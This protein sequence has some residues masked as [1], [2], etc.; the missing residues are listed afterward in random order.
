MKYDLRK[1]MLNAWKIY[2]K[3]GCSFSEALKRAWITAKAAEEN[4][5]R[6]EAAKAAAGIQEDARTWYG[7]TLEGREVI[8]EVKALFQAVVIDGA[9]KTGTRVLSFFGESQTELKPEMV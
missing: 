4:K 3:A 1:L 2:R 5:K 7:W 8:H 6:I 9:T